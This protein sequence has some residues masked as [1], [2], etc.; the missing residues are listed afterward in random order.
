MDKISG[1]LNI[2]IICDPIGSNNSG[3]VFSTIRFGKLLKA[4]GNH[5]IFVA[6]Q[7]PEHKDLSHDHGVTTYRYRSIYIPRGGG[8]RLAF[9]TVKELKKVFEEEKIDVV[10]IT[11][12]MSGG[13]VA[14]KAARA[15]GIRIV[16]H[17]HSQP[18][19][20]FIDLP[21]ILQ[22]TLNGLWN[23]YLM[24]VYS[25]AESLIYP[26]QMAKGLLA[27]LSPADQ[28]STVV[29]N[30]IHLEQF[31]PRDVG[32]FH[33]RFNVPKDAVKLLYVGRLYP[34][35]SLDTLV[36]AVPHIVKEHPHTHIMIAGA[37]HLR[38]KLEKLAASLGAD[39]HITF[40]GLVSEEDKIHAYNASDMFVLPSLAELEGMVVLEAMAC[41]K[42]I[43]VSDAKMSASRF[44][45]DGNGFL[46]KTQDHEH[47]AEQALKLIRNAELR[48]QMGNASLENIKRYD[49]HK[50][51]DLLEEIYHSALKPKRKTEE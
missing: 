12:P 50:S 15:L 3:S 30:G 34:E 22:P 24:W 40:L 6:A 38:P 20:L 19:N 43:L 5:V 13:I 33:E 46:F 17:S 44:F 47:L 31:R 4:R 16:A 25:K 8:W 7:T 1:K 45:V 39:K 23:R 51:V 18:E 21:K 14:I 11:L 27:G 49:I 42:P 41:G 35:K 32:D 36:K 9:P 2:A 10:H 28:P 37:G 29:S 26:S 48:A